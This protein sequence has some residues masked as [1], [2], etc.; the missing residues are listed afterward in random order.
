VDVFYRT[1]KPLSSQ[2]GDY[3]LITPGASV[4]FG[5]PFT[6]LDTV[7]FGVGIEQTQIK[8]NAGLPQS[9]K[10]Y[11]DLFGEKSLSVPLTLGW[12][13]DGRDSVLVPTSGRYQR[14]NVEWGIAGDTRYLRSNYQFQQYLPLSQRF[15]LGFNAEVGWGKG[16]SGK[17]YP[18][19]KN[20]YGGGLGT[21]R[22]FDQNSLGPVDVD[23][24]YVGGAKRVNLNT[25]L[26]VP[27]PGTGMDRTLRL[28]GYVDAGNVWG[29]NE[30]LK[31][32]DLRASAGIG[33]SWI[34]PVGP[35]KLSY[36]QPIKKTDQDKIQKLQFQIG[37]A[38]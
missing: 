32:G 18:V 5:V 1:S 13:R 4:R 17:P 8:G 20:F 25:E 29:E 7:Y 33:I 16:L 2:G 9:Y 27:F 10:D 3:E 24:A 19:F 31:F 12:S 23:G 30:N 35:L 14:L 38:F 36:G 37:T 28:F 21:V 22:G 6:E 15:T 26:Y 11:R 34:S